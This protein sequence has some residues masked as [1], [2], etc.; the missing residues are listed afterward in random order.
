MSNRTERSF[1]GCKAQLVRRNSRLIEDRGQKRFYRNWGDRHLSEK[2]PAK[3]GDREITYQVGRRKG[4]IRTAKAK[5]PAQ[6]EKLPEPK[7]EPF[8][9][10]KSASEREKAK[11]EAERA[12]S[13]SRQ[14]EGME[15]A[16]SSEYIEHP[17]NPSPAAVSG[18][19]ANRAPD[20]SDP[21]V[22]TNPEEKATPISG[23]SSRLM[24]LLWRSTPLPGWRAATMITWVLSAAAAAC[25]LGVV[26]RLLT[27]G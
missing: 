24:E 6:D 19:S 3:P 22:R 12:H 21:A 10:K 9:S 2:K 27:F 25:T 15:A 23:E 13:R 4:R 5:A 16:K 11:T 7:R 14:V 26:S 20:P 17:S 1:F 18:E 8:K